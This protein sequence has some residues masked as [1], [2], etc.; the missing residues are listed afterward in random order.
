MRV[1]GVPVHP[2][3]D[4]EAESRHVLRQAWRGCQIRKRLWSIPR[5]LASK[6]RVLQ[7]SVFKSMAWASGTRFWT[8]WE[9]QQIR[10]V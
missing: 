8:T 2:H 5:C 6:M 7:L 3:R 4:A 1:L 9:L 10:I